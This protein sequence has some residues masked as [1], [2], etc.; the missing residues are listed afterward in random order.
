MLRFIRSEIALIGL[1]HNPNVHLIRCRL[2]RH[3]EY[4]K[5]RMRIPAASSFN[6]GVMISAMQCGQ[7]RPRRWVAVTCPVPTNDSP[8]WRIGR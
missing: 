5:V 6:N 1:Y 7:Q 4:R 3:K 2:Q 8:N